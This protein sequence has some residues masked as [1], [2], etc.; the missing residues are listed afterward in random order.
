VKENSRGGLLLGFGLLGFLANFSKADVYQNLKHNHETLSVG[1]LLGISASRLGK[2]D[3]S[4]SKTLCLHVSQI[5]PPALDIEIL[6]NVQTSALIGIG[7]I[8]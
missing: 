5:L 4:T 6:L 7:L 2:A 8:H 1:I 3:E